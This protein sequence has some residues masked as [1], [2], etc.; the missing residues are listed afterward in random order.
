MKIKL[1]Y[2]L[3][4]SALVFFGC[5]QGPDFK[6]P[7]EI[8]TKTYLPKQEEI[9]FKKHVELGKKVQADWR[10]FFQ[11][12]GLNTLLEQT[13]KNNYDLASAKETLKQAKELVK[14]KDGALLPQVSLGADAGRQKYGTALFGPS[15]FTIPPFSY[16]EAG[17]SASWKP[18]IFGS[19]KREIERQKALQTYQMHEVDVLYITLIGNTASTALDVASLKAQILTCKEIIQEDKNILA[20]V[21]KSYR[22][23]QASQMDVLN[24]QSRLDDDKTALPSLEQSLS[25]SSHELA[26][27]VG[28]TPSE[29]KM[30]NLDF[31]DFTFPQKILLR[32]PSTLLENRPDILAARSSLHVSSAAVGVA[33]ANRYPNLTLSA[34]MMMEALKPENIFNIS[35]NAWA[36]AAELSAPIFDGGTLK[37]QENAAKHA[38]TASLF[39][40]RQTILIAFRQVADALTALAHDDE[41]TTLLKESLNTRENALHVVS[42][43]YEIGTVGLLQVYDAQRKKAKVQLEFLHVRQQRYL[44]YIRLFVVLGGSSM[45]VEKTIVKI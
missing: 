30:P 34:N 24:A 27:L 36:I 12:K 38:Y 40:Y 25:Q 9:L 23:G 45:P 4:G 15:D 42:K 2:L 32:L 39:Q 26:I 1:Q 31:D 37:A 16:Y 44:D 41:E 29:F 28:K 35:N 8:Q 22:L 5:T 43:S 20:L 14:A 21:K 13:I 11:S 3:L 19:K 33:E 10:K 17:L 18:D 7:H 6:A